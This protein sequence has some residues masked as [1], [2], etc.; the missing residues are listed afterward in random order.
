MAA[1]NVHGLFSIINI[2]RLAF[3]CKPDSRRPLSA[4]ATHP[5]AAVHPG[6]H[7]AAGGARAVTAAALVRA[8]ARGS[9]T[10]VVIS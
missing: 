7:R 3:E 8:A 10:S 2:N 4:I 9:P 5:H 6:P 1:Y